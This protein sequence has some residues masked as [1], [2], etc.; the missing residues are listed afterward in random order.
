MSLR[1]CSAPATVFAWL[2]TDSDKLTGVNP[3]PLGCHVPRRSTSSRWLALACPVITG[4]Q[5]TV[6]ATNRLRQ[7]SPLSRSGR[8]RAIPNSRATALGPY[9]LSVPSAPLGS[10]AFSAPTRVSDCPPESSNLRFPPNRS[11]TLYC[12]CSPWL[13]LYRS[14]H[15]FLALVSTSLYAIDA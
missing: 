1:H 5:A 15:V 7:C 9:K 8:Q 14:V 12:V 2:T 11:R 13:A 3:L 4:G 6:K 10:Q